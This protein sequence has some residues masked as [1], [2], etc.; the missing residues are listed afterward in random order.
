MKFVFDDGI[1][2][3]TSADSYNGPDN[4]GGGLNVNACSNFLR[5]T[6]GKWRRCEERS[7]HRLRQQ[8]QACR[9]VDEVMK[10]VVFFK[11]RQG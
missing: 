8:I 3:M 1:I 4:R 6:D 11:L 10:E 9:S 5:A 7:E 2:E